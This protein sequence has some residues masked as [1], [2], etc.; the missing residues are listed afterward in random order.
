LGDK[1][2][3]IEMAIAS[4]TNACLL[5]PAKRFPKI[6]RVTQNNLAAAYS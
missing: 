4:Y 1:A 3:N 2:Q 5:E 6:G